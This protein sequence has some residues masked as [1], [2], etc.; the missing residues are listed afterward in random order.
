MCSGSLTNDGPEEE[1][2]VDGKMQELHQHHARGKQ[3]T[4]DSRQQQ[5]LQ[6]DHTRVTGVQERGR[7]VERSR[8]KSREVE[9][10]RESEVG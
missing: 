3:A 2:K 1:H 5:P 10:E 4:T 6:W 9:R 8:E 7:E